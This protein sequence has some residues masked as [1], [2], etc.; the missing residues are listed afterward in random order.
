MRK[1]NMKNQLQ[2]QNEKSKQES[3]R[4]EKRKRSR[5][6]R[7]I[8]LIVLL[9]ILCL[10]LALLAAF[11][12]MFHRGKG[13]VL[14]RPEGVELSAPD[15]KEL[16]IMLEDNGQT[17]V[18]Q[19]QTYRYNENVTS[20]LFMG[21]DREEMNDGADVI[22]NSGQ[23]DCIF[24]LA[25]DLDS[26]K[27]SLLSISRDAMVD[28]NNYDVDGNLF[29]VEHQQLCLAYA[30]G[31]GQETSCENVVNSVSRLFYGI[32]I[33]SYA[34]INLSAISELNDAIGG[35]EVTVL[36]DSGLAYTSFVPGTTVLLT[37]DQAERYVRSRDVEVL[38][39]NVSRM[40]RQKQYIL[41]YI[42]K[43]LQMM[44][45]DITLPVTL[46]QMVSKDGNMVTNIDISKVTYLATQLL[47]VNFSEE[48][49]K[50]IPGE[51]VMGEKY[52]EYI[53]DDQA[54]YEIILDT[55]YT[56]VDD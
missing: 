56:K 54:L 36:D 37:G 10:L 14:Q 50:N 28:V 40:A 17:V 23:A 32:P 52:A 39:S 21:V 22:G 48:N 4:R 27:I 24:L 9:V 30:Y 11:L 35:V 2:K 3:G 20:I 7:R 38:D 42:Q 49:M 44:K 55:F 12:I 5:K 19:G 8:V 29:S 15:R 16:D 31:D 18:Y 51:V 45:E 33:Q 26:G 6:I 53:V 1:Q 46:Y 41:A 47:N 13:A 43:A 34:A 25:W